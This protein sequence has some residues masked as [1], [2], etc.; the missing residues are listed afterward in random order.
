MAIYTG[1]MRQQDEARKAAKSIAAQQAKAEAGESKR[2]GRS[3]FFGSIG[4]ALM[5]GALSTLGGMALTGITGGVIN[6][7]TMKLI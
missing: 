7:M 4:G 6:P 1:G 3:G 2:K 5:G